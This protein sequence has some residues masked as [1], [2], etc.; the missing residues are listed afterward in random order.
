M[1]F[2]GPLGMLC[3]LVGFGV[4]IY[5]TISKFVHM[6]DFSLTNRPSFYIALTVMI[7]GM[8]LFLTGF[9]AELISRNSPGRN[10][11]LI[12]QKLG[13]ENP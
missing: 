2:F 12:E 1:H 4:S 9:V 5:L 10:S 13:L 8:Q 7:I 6:A 11:Y 3:F